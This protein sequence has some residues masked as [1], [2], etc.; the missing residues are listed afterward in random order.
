MTSQSLR[1]AFAAAILIPACGGSQS[2]AE[3]PAPPA[4]PAASAAVPSE[5]TPAAQVSAAPTPATPAKTETPEVKPAVRYTGAFATPESAFYDETNDRY[6]VSNINGKPWEADGN[7]YISVLSPDGTVTTPKWIAGGVKK[8]KLDAPKGM[9]IVGN[10]LYV[11]DITV[12]RKFDVKDGAPKGEIAIPGSTFLNDVSASP[13]G[14]IYVSDTG[15]KAEFAPA[16]TDAVYVIEKDKVK[17]IAKMKDLGGPNGVLATADG[18]LVVTFGTGE[19][20]KLDGDGKR[21][22]I[23]PVGEGGLDG[24]VAQGD[25]LLVSSWK[26]NAIYRGKLHG[27][28]EIVV[29]NVK[30]PADIGFDKKRS[31]VLVPRFMDDAVEAYDVK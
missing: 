31:R 28:F 16:G 19:L 8:V 14:K 7:G 24:I 23:T 27:N 29:P 5:A 30:A 9:A 17:P 26:A 25:N 1:F 18:V 13:D 10:I 15:V 20:Y 12:V 4:P 22:D 3:P 6:L 11:A 21:K 2:S